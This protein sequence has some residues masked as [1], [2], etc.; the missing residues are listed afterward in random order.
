MC[1]GRRLFAHS[2]CIDIDTSSF[3]DIMNN[4]NSGDS[5]LSEQRMHIFGRTHMSNR[6]HAVFQAAARKRCIDRLEKD[7]NDANKKNCI[8]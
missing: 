3:R 1:P 6:M 7:A 4:A 5:I 2:R 8:R